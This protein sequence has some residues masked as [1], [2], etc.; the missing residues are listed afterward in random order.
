MQKMKQ[1]LNDADKYRVIKHDPT[2]KIEKKITKSLKKLEG[3][4]C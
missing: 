1:I 3:R 4:T 2:L